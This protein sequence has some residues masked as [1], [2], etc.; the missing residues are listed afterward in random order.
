MKE[1]NRVTNEIHAPKNL[2][3]R[4]KKAV[5]EEEQ[6]MEEQQKKTVVFRRGLTAAA[7]ILVVGVLTVPA[8]YIG[9]GTQTSEESEW[10]E[11]TGNKVMLGQEK[12]AA[13]EK[14][15]RDRT[16]DEEAGN[17]ASGITASETK[18][19]EIKALEQAGDYSELTQEEAV[20]VN[21]I[22]VNVYTDSDGVIIAEF[23]VDEVYYQAVQETGDMDKLLADIAEYLKQLSE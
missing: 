1:Y 11:E 7:A 13:P 16:G 21:G 18:E 12:D 23:A 9:M 3:E 2:I 14:L 22:M 20:E 17:V 8:L 15:E 5:R 4:T 10:Q 6:R 19:S